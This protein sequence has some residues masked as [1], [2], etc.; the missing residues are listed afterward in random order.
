[1]VFTR[2][3]QIFGDQKTLV[4]LPYRGGNP[5]SENLGNILELGV[6]FGGLLL[7]EKN[8]LLALLQDLDKK[9]RN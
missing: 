7:K 6:K 3:L 8:T 5:R 1:M 2:W 4:L 9:S